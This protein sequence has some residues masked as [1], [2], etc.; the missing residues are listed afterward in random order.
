MQGG[1]SR[2]KHGLMRL[3]GCSGELESALQLAEEHAWSET[4][5][6]GSGKGDK[7]DDNDGMGYSMEG[8]QDEQADR[9]TTKIRRGGG[10]SV[11]AGESKAKS[12]SGYRW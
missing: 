11:E 9:G 1:V 2:S 6:E 10:K 4:L 8:R 5:P 7:S 12:R 3:L